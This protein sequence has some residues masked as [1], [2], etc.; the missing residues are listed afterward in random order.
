LS[1][2]RALLRRTNVFIADEAT[3]SVD[4]ETDEMVQHT[5]RRELHDAT[6]I[7]IAHRLRTIID[8]DSVIVLSEG[9]VQEQGSPADLLEDPASAFSELCRQTNE[10][11]ELKN[12]AKLV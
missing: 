5:L 4:F 11:E 10:L 3:A 9:V 6:V 7:T 1:I 8:V 12:L 2:A